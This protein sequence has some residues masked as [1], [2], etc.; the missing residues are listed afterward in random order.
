M[1]NG[2]VD[3]P[4]EIFNEEH[5]KKISRKKAQR[6]K[7]GREHGKQRGFSCLIGALEKEAEENGH[8]QNLKI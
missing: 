1:Y 6:Q 2:R 5:Q 3:I 4:E 7:P 8:M